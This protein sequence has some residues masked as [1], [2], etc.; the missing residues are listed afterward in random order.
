MRI[1]SKKMS[2]IFKLLICLSALTGIVIQSGLFDGE[3]NSE[4]FNYYTLIS[5]VLCM[6]YFGFASVYLIKYNKTLFPILKGAL[7][8]GITVTGLVFHFLLSS[9]IF[10]MGSTFAV[11][12][13]LLHYIVPIFCIFDWLIFDEKGKY[14]FK[15][16]FKWLVIP[17]L[18]FI[19]VIIG[20]EFGMDF[21]LIT[22]SRYPYFFIDVESLGWLNVI[23]YVILLNIFFLLLGYIFVFIDRK[24][25]F[26]K[27]FLHF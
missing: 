27:K 26:K 25:S 12:N 21:S 7:T 2:V 13:I 10:N 3:F 24:M 11:A 14:D 20:V 8:M 5:N 9:T 22:E 16:P 19:Y 15:S 17:D 4:I 1:K 18:Y 6:L 23:K